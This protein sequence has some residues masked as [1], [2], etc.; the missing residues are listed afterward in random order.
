MATPAMAVFRDTPAMAVFRDT[1]AME[2]FRDTPAMAVY[3][4]A[5]LNGIPSK[6]RGTA[7]ER[8]LAARCG[9]TMATTR[10]YDIIDSD[11]VP[12]E[13]KCSGLCW[14]KKLWKVN[15][16]GVQ[17]KKHNRLY[18]VVYHPRGLDAY[19]HDRDEAM[20]EDT[21][22][23]KTISVYGPSYED[24]FDKAL[25]VI[26]AKL[27]GRYAAARFTCDFS[28]ET[29][30]VALTRGVE[31]Y[32]NTPLAAMPPSV[33]GGRIEDWVVT[34]LPPGAQKM[35]P[36]SSFDI[37]AHDG[38]RVEVKSSQLQYDKSEKLWYVRFT[39]IKNEEWDHLIMVIFTP[40]R[41][42]AWRTQ[43]K[44]PGKVELGRRGKV[45]GRKVGV[46]GHVGEEDIA[47]ASKRIIAT[48]SAPT[49]DDYVGFGAPMATYTL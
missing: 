5:Q 34:L 6:L 37:K 1:R 4:G 24:D 14:D 44:P 32:I 13:V 29:V 10:D 31:A 41:L 46:Y 7:V 23:C 49:P 39:G 42:V 27:T 16:Q 18:V 17:K 40:T 11:G 38:A 9:G 19:R 12:A 21:P 30:P 35:P 48:M 45:V 22:D 36:K 28:T 2:V 8:W 33:R 25:A 15:F 26:T 43:R 47:A 3:R 20:D